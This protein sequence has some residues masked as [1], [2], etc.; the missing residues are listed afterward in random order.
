MRSICVL[1]ALCI[2]DRKGTELVHAPE[3]GSI[4][5]K[6]HTLTASAHTSTLEDRSLEQPHNPSVAHSVCPTLRSIPG[7]SQ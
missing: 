7:S 4:V 2:P 1:S 3:L 6:T 5:A